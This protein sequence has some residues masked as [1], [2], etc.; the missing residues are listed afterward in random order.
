MV[1]GAPRQF[2]SSRQDPLR[3]ALPRTSVG[4]VQK[5]ALRSGGAAVEGDL[6][7]KRVGG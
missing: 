3:S 7:E 2:Q 1:P 4:K 6:M 5:E